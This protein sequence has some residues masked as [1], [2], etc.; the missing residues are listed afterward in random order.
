MWRRL[1]IRRHMRRMAHLSMGWP[2][3]Y[4]SGWSL[5]PASAF[6]IWAAAMGS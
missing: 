3:A 5:N 2:E 1:G 4:W 6:L